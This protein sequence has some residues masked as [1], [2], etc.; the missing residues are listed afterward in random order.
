[1][2]AIATDLERTKTHL[3]E[4][5]RGWFLGIVSGH[6]TAGAAISF[7]FSMPAAY[8]EDIRGFLD[9]DTIRERYP[10]LGLFFGEPERNQFGVLFVHVRITPIASK[11]RSR[12]LFALKQR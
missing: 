7:S 5:T 3:C 9:H 11:E 6:L 8:V 10:D 4:F 2:S 1:M 12:R